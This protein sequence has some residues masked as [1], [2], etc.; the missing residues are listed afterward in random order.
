MKTLYEILDI[1]KTATA[2]QIKKAYRKMAKK[3]HPDRSGEEAQFKEVQLAWEVL[4]DVEKKK[5]YDETGVIH[6]KANNEHLFNASI[7]NQVFSIVIL[8]IINQ[9][10]AMPNALC[11][12]LNEINIKEMMTAHMKNQN[13]VAKETR[14]TVA[15]ILVEMRQLLGKF[16]IDDG[17]NV[18]EGIIKGSIKDS[19]KALDS[20]EEGMVN[21]QKAIEYLSKYGFQFK[22]R[23]GVYKTR[24]YVP[25]AIGVMT[26]GK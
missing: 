20:I 12:A 16:T 9:R 4:G 1:E 3:Y 6:S 24:P 14:Q 13:A 25:S 5:I 17:D 26:F 18:M 2:D 19:E 21:V 10:K 7:L 11:C 15:T 8:E 22:D 23:W